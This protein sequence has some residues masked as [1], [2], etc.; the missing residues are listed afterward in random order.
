MELKAAVVGLAALGA[1]ALT[2]GP[3]AAM[4]NGLPQAKQIA[5]QAANVEQARLV[6]ARGRCWHRPGWRGARAAWGPRRAWGPRTV[7]RRP[8]WSGAYAWSPG[9]TWG[10][11]P[12][13]GPRPWGSAWGA[14]PGWGAGWGWNRTWW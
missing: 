8:A 13:W 5:G 4:P 12:G 1:V 9:P 7:W 11:S 10:A 2:A 14:S 3:A 6:C